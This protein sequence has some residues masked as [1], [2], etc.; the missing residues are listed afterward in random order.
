MNMKR[1]RLFR[2]KIKELERVTVDYYLT[3]DEACV[4]EKYGICLVKVSDGD[5]IEEF[6]TVDHVCRGRDEA[7]RLIERL[8]QGEAMPV[9]LSEIIDDYLAERR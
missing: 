6:T 5:L 8:A 1:E 7:E 9:S 4:H 3:I 2:V